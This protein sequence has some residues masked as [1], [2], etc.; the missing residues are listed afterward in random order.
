M[1]YCSQFWCVQKRRN[2]YSKNEV[3]LP[4][5]SIELGSYGKGRR[6][7]N[8]LSPQRVGLWT[9]THTHT[10]FGNS[11]ISNGK[12]LVFIALPWQLHFYINNKIIS[13]ITISQHL[14]IIKVSKTTN[15]SKVILNNMKA[16][17][18]NRQ[19]TEKVFSR[20]NQCKWLKNVFFLFLLRS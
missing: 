4:C 12:L 16:W 3:C 13:K 18:S 7:T 17:W 20:G 6:W 19:M 5:N 15:T 2:K 11:R 10:K 14:S 8:M 1:W 9:H